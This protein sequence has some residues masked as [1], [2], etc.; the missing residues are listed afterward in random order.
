MGNCCN[1]KPVPGGRGPS[2]PV[3]HSLVWFF[4]KATQDMKSSWNPLCKSLRR[5]NYL[6]CVQESELNAD[7]FLLGAMLSSDVWKVQESLLKVVK[8]F[9]NKSVSSVLLKWNPRSSSSASSFHPYL[10]ISWGQ[11]KVANN[12]WALCVPEMEHVSG[13][14]SVRGR[15]VQ[16]GFATSC[17]VTGQVTP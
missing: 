14:V 1:R 5:T 8:H 10:L 17:Y 7:W 2:Y 16:R 3:N 9:L 15:M 6:W 4:R 13:K 12:D 11:R